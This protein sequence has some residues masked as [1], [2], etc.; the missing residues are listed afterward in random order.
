LGFVRIIL[1][2]HAEPLGNVDEP[3]CT[4]IPDHALPVSPYPR[5]RQTLELLDI[6]VTASGISS[7]GCRSASQAPTSTTGSPGS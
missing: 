5:T 1:L 2:K 7:P 4:R 3:A 6:G